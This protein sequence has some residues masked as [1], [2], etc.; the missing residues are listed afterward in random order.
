MGG[1]RLYLSPLCLGYGIETLADSLAGVAQPVA[2]KVV[3]RGFDRPR[4]HGMIEADTCPPVV[5]FSLESR[6]E[7]ECRDGCRLERT[8]PRKKPWYKRS[9]WILRQFQTESLLGGFVIVVYHVRTLTCPRS[10]REL[11]AIGY[12]SC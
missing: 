9:E 8:G 4:R 7:Q 11:I 10:V 6:N 5:P 1:D 12:K 3:R 2:L